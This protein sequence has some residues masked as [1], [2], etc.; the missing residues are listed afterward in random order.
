L[1]LLCVKSCHY[2]RYSHKEDGLPNICSVILPWGW[3]VRPQG[4]CG[5]AG[6]QPPGAGE[7]DQAAPC[8]AGPWAPGKD[9]GLCERHGA[10]PEP[11]PSP[12]PPGTAEQ[13][14]GPLGSRPR[15]AAP[16]ETSVCLRTPTALKQTEVEARLTEVRVSVYRGGRRL[17]QCRHHLEEPRRPRRRT[18]TADGHLPGDQVA[19]DRSGPPAGRTQSCAAFRNGLGSEPPAQTL[20]GARAE[21]GVPSNP[22]L[23]PRAR[24]PVTFGE[25]ARLRLS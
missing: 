7:R 22:S 10:V 13:P 9:P 17:A 2:E 15:A 4:K 5:G 1:E 20:G 21:A 14:V 11:A 23:G 3:K 16:E 19:Q 8:G 12:D 24:R 25:C 6:G 18:Q